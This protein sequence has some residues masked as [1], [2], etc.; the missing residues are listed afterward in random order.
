[1]FRKLSSVIVLLLVVCI[2]S[3][4]GRY[5]G[6]G[7]VHAILEQGRVKFS[8]DEDDYTGNEGRA[9]AAVDAMAIKWQSEHPEWAFESS[10]VTFDHQTCQ[11]TVQ[12]KETGLIEK[13]LVA[14]ARKTHKQG[15]EE[16]GR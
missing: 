3:G 5:P 6:P 8:C 7:E 15:Y 12:L 11:M 1:M 10:E 2:L 14:P 9:R 13:K 4:C 16:S